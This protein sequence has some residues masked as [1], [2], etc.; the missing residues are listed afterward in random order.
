MQI[1]NGGALVVGVAA[2]PFCMVDDRGRLSPN[3]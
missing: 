1:R 3:R 2:L